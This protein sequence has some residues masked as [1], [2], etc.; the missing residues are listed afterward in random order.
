[1]MGPSTEDL[2]PGGQSP[3]IL[4]SSEPVAPPVVETRVAR[5]RRALRPVPGR[6]AAIV[7]AAAVMVGVGVVSLA[8]PAPPSAPP[9][10]PGDGV[11]VSPASA[12]TSSLFC[13]PGAGLDA[14]AGATGVV[15]LTNTS[16][17]TVRGVMTVVQ[18]SGAPAVRRDLTVPPLGS[19]DVVPAQGLPA[20]ATASTFSFEGGGVTGTMVVGGPVGWSTAPCASAVSSEW[21]FVGG[22]T[23]TGL[24]DLSLYN[25]TAAQA[26]VGVS[27]L[28]PDGNVL[29]PQAYQ[30]ITLTPGQ[31]VVAG[32]G[33][34]VQNQ[35][36]V[37]T[38]VQT[39]SGAIVAT[40]LDRLVVKSGTGLAL[41]AGTPAPATTWRF[42]QTTAVQGGSVTLSVANPHASPVTA[43]VTVGLSSATVTPKQLTVPGHS[44][45]AVAASAVAGWPRGAPYSVTVAA[46]APV[47]VGRSVVAAPSGASPQAGLTGGTVTTASSWLIVG[48]GSPGNPLMAGATVQSLAV[49][50]PGSSPVEV[51]VTPLAG[52]RPVAMVKVAA[53]G[54]VVFGAAEVGGLRPLVVTATG[55]VSVEVDD[56]PAGAPGIVSAS[57]FPL[58]A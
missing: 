38:L 52:G 27:F 16:R 10:S 57:G 24:L 8:A 28:T 48:P 51:V 58:G 3:E 32:L 36:V 31:L 18:G 55:P 43:L 19:T 39:S 5:R 26:V 22:A 35:Q 9:T 14:G 46:S 49:A 4:A 29:V 54:L 45:V 33:A 17:T 56:G 47:I 12:R 41:V 23:A 53:N 2:P 13:A 40:E 20:G 50:N 6:T 30:G 1:M 34:Y 25:P 15:V 21:D 7:T 37:A 44:V 42:A 11:R